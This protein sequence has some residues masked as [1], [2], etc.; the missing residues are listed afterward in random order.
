MIWDSFKKVASLHFEVS[1]NPCLK[2][3]QLNTKTDNQASLD[4]IVAKM[5]SKLDKSLKTMEWLEWL[6]LLLI[7]QIFVEGSI[8]P[9]KGQRPKCKIRQND[10]DFGLEV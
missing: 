2:P 9:C 6:R 5:I 4:E 8:W 7:R 1:F 10:V 3:Q